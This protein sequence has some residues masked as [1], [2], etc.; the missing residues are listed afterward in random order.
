MLIGQPAEEDISGAKR[1]LDEGLLTYFPKPD[2]AVAMHVG[3]ELP[4]GKVGVISGYRSASADALRVTIYGKG[5][6]GAMPDTTIDPVVIA[7]RTVVSLQTIVSREVKPGKAAVVT[8]EYVQA[9]TKSNIISDRAELGIT[10]RTYK[11]EVRRQ[12]LGAIARIVRAE[13]DAADAPREPS[14]ENYQSTDA[15]YNDSILAHRLRIVLEASLGEDNV[16]VAEPAM[17]SEDFSY[18]IMAGIPSF[19]FSLGGANPQKFAQT[20]AT[21]QTLPSNHS[22]LFAPDVDP[23]LRTGITAEVA[24]LRNLF[25]GSADALRKH[26]SGS[27]E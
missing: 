18:F 23:A 6:H 22:P 19:Y 25:Q 1:M 3:N 14:I 7:A 12:I 17:T 24:A 2:A 9:G 15:V 5:G 27:K 13:A 11:P 4:A 20:V 10:V 26:E 21:V 16:L 8:V